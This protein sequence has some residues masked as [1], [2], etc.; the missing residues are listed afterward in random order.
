MLLE[1]S[2]MGILQGLSE[3]SPRY[4]N[5]PTVSGTSVERYKSPKVLI[6]F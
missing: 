2:N 5:L 3:G 6:F 1:L 4:A